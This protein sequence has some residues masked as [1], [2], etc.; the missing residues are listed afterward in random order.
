MSDSPFSFDEAQ[1]NRLFPFYLLIN[2]DECIDQY[3]NSLQKLVNFPLSGLSVRSVFKITRSTNSEFISL[4]QTLNELVILEFIQESTIKLKGQFEFL[5]H[6]NQ[7]LFVGAPWF[8][9]VEEA[10]RSH[11]NI[12]DFAIHDPLID[13]INVFKTQEIVNS[14]IKKLL[15]TLNHQRDELKRLSLIAEETING[16][17]VTDSKCRIQ[18]VNKAFEKISGYSLS[19]VVGKDPGSILQGK[20]TDPDSKKYMQEKIKREESFECE[21][22]NYN[23]QGKPYWIKISGQPL[24]DKNGKLTQFFAL[25]EDIS[26]R[27]EHEQKI[28]DFEKRFR[29]VLEK[30]GD[31]YWEHDYLVNKTFFSSIDNKL[32]GY[33]KEELQNNEGLWLNNIH[34]DDKYM[35]EKTEQSYREGLI[36]NHSLEYRM[37]NKDGSI[38]WVLDRGVVL[39]RDALGFPVK[40]VGT[41]T[42]IT[43][44][45]EAE[46]SL[47]KAE[48]RW[49]F[50]LEGA[51]DGVWEYNF[52]TGEVYF[53]K[54]YKLML[55]HTDENFKNELF[56]WTSRIHPDDLHMIEKTDH[57]YEKGLI[58]HHSREYRIKNIQGEYLWIL[59]RGMVISKTIDGKPLRLIGIHTN[60]TQR[61]LIAITLEQNEK[62]FRA[63]SENLPGVVYEYI[64][65]A[66]GSHGFKFISPSIEKIFGIKPHDFIQSNKY[67]H[68]YDQ[69]ILSQKINESKDTNQSFTYE[70]RII[71]PDRGIMW[72]SATSSF[73]YEMQDGSRVFTGIILDITEKKLAEKKLE[74]QRR[75]YEDILNQIPAD[76]AVF[77][78]NHAYLFL[79]PVAIKD[80]ELRKWL[81]GKRDEDY[82]QLKNKPIELAETRR[83]VFNKVI[84]TKKLHSWEEKLVTPEGKINSFLRNMYPVLDEKGEIKL[85]IGYGLDISERKNIEEKLQIN[86][87]RY[88]D[89]FNYS[90]ALICTH[91]MQGRILSVNPA[92]CEALG[93][94]SEELVGKELQSFI[95]VKDSDKFQPEYLDKIAENEKVSGVFRVV[96]KNGNKLFLLYQNYRVKE[97]GLEPYVIGFSQDITERVKAENE[98]MLAKKLTEDASHAKEIFLANMSHE[99]RTPMSGILGIAGLL[100]KTALDKEQKNYIKLITESA[101]NLL[102]IVNEVLDI[103]KI[104]SGKFEFE[105]VHFK[106]SEKITTTI[107]SFQYK[108]EEK[109]LLLDFTNNLPNDLIIQ[110]DP[111]RLSQI[112]N[113]LLSNALKFTHEGKIIVSAQLLTKD[114]D[115]V[116]IHFSVKDTGIGI[117]DNRLGVIFD[118]FVQASS[119]T[120][121]KYGGTGLGLSICKNLVEL[122]GGKI[123]VSSEENAGTTFTFTLP[124]PIGKTSLLSD[125]LKVVVDFGELHK[126]KVLVAEDVELNQFLA[127]HILESWGIIVDIANNGK[128]AVESVKLKNYDLILMDIQMPEMDG[129][130]ATQEIRKIEDPQK[131]AIPIIA[132]TANALKGDDQRYLNAGMN[133]YITKPYTEE[134]LYKVISKFLKSDTSKHESVEV[135]N[136][137]TEIPV[138]EESLY[139]LTMVNIIGKNSP[140]FVR[141]MIKLFLETIPVDI[142]KLKLAAESGERDKIGFTAH[143]MK[144]TIDS[145]GIT[146]ITAT[147]RK[148]ELKGEHQETDESIR[149]M[150]D[151]VNSVLQKVI[152]KMKAD[153]TDL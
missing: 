23:K 16:V 88:R 74:D 80:P 68:P 13:I 8:D 33:T 100:S 153:F 57:Q 52:Q 139:D 40:T 5:A 1:F 108:A 115:N 107:Q 38:R 62:Q 141:T 85:V 42:D 96:Q 26:E 113:N 129:I 125:E 54:G 24:F 31:N 59:D 94:S 118:P 18:W 126:C 28:L 92:I 130:V 70:G 36:S 35:M 49:Q 47:K 148:L 98:L 30:L 45:K 60:I 21:I 56:E 134:R 150:I 46:D 66:D 151:E 90:Q 39:E 140:T 127:K 111:F 83:A 10:N 29:T 11:L 109:G 32:L 116:L 147:I 4:D 78:M 105:S 144:S 110:G 37:F 124:Y 15:K 65:N 104:A 86:E 119:D 34:P 89:L 114:D 53:S 6:K 27:K 17:I 112:L 122:Q 106:I 123:A 95:P 25:E 55:G 82:C 102:V 43:Y 63:L 99:I 12:T 14:D 75:F 128:E 142:Q 101:N 2:A 103:E 135:R 138:A 51:G 20:D 131:S 77:D 48:E 44:L 58:T 84:E 73:S 19:E 67:I 137:K 9:T 41:H 50:A 136:E 22:L 121:R 72:H 3:G 152:Q 81:I 91:D 93:Y 132:L 97:E 61:K 145:M 87:K 143:K 79:N 76:I 117:P 133:D 7:V 120:T 69:K 64:F 146:S 149:S 71:T